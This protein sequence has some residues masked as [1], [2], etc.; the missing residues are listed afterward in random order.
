MVYGKIKNYLKRYIH[1][2]PIQKKISQHIIYM[3]NLRKYFNTNNKSDD[4]KV[5]MTT[6]K[7]CQH[8]LVRYEYNYICNYCGTVADTEFIDDLRDPSELSALNY[9]H[10]K[11]Y[12]RVKH[13]MK[14]IRKINC[15]RNSRK[16]NINADEIIQNSKILK[17]DDIDTVKGKIND[18][19]INQYVIMN[20]LHNKYLLINTDLQEQIKSLYVKVER[21]YFDKLNINSRKNFLNN[22]FILKKILHLLN[23]D[24]IASKIHCLKISKNI[25]NYEKIWEQIVEYL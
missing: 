5:D 13:L 24:D 25:S 14:L 7:Y 20:K 23:H 18:F 17:D 10:N 15:N 11:P 2:Y 22:Y 16:D 1:I 21:I 4:M 3:E 8:E 6:C 12:Q 9:K 19:K